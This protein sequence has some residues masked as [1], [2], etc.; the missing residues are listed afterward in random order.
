VLANQ[1]E[2]KRAF[3]A[4]IGGVFDHQAIPTFIVAGDPE[5]WDS[6]IGH[7]GSPAS[8]LRHELAHQLSAAVMPRQPHWF[9]E[10]LA[11][12]LETVRVSDDGGSV[13]AG[14]MNMIAFQKY[15]YTQ[16]VPLRRLLAWTGWTDTH[17]DGER[18]GLY[19]EAWMFVHWLYDTRAE[20]FAHYQADLAKG[21][22]PERALAS[23]FPGFNADNLDTQIYRY[24]HEATFHE[25]SRPLR[26]TEIT[27]REEPMSEAEV[28][29]AR[30]RIA[31]AAANDFKGGDRDALVT[32]G[33]IEATLTL[34][35][36][37]TIVET[38]LLVTWLPRRTRQALAGTVTFAHPDDARA[39]ELLGALSDEA[40][41][42]ERAYRRARELRTSQACWPSHCPDI[43]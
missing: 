2:F 42:K 9:A 38:A 19:G 24:A 40:G 10:G 18:Y 16:G 7:L 22:D 15:L 5:V 29:L 11:Q 26:R 8:I 3:A 28:H 21:I 27:F 41:E 35:L 1:N 6:W 4:D 32:A 12:F 23:A 25:F 20:A 17:G 43:R 37:D 36:D 33:R 31:F 14:G 30:A 34:E 39:F 13:V